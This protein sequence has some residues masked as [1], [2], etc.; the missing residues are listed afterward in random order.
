MKLVAIYNV[1]DDWDLYFKSLENISPLVDGT[2]CIG[3]S[4]SNFG[5]LS[6]IETIHDLHQDGRDL[7]FQ[8]EP[9]TQWDARTN[10]TAKRNFGLQKARELGY[11]HFIMMDA[12]EFYDREEFLREKKRFENPK[13]MGLVCRVKCY[14]GS[15]TLTIGYDTTLVPFIHKLTPTLR[16]EFN[17]NYPFAWTFVDGVPFTHTKKIR[18]DPTRSLNINDDVEWSDITMHHFSWIRKDPAKKIRN[19]TA[20]ANL[21]RSTV[22][23]DL[24]NAK[25]G[26]FCEFYGKTLQEVPNV[27]GL[28]VTGIQSHL[29]PT[30]QTNVN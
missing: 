8:W 9:N 30:G 26:Y 23:Q 3:S 21:E 5:E 10:E 6:Y 22:V 29:P 11:T 4:K 12:D 24:A 18:I 16:H 17:K 14:F 28:Y 15:P 13:L 27:F 2:I 1:W 19:S 25:P 20:K 7:F